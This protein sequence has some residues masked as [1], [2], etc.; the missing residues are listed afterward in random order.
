MTTINSWRY[1]HINPILITHSF[2]INFIVWHSNLKV[3]G[4][5]TNS[6]IWTIL[7]RLVT[8][9]FRQPEWWWSHKIYGRD[10]P[11]RDI[12]YLMWAT[13]SNLWTKMRSDTFQ[14]CVS[15]SF[16]PWNC[17]RRKNNAVRL[18][19]S[20]LYRR[21]ERTHDQVFQKPPNWKRWWSVIFAGDMDMDIRLEKFTVS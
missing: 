2:D 3:R 19:A 21:L 10:S 1:F 11:A 4:A 15:F 6:T 9:A 8:T 20:L 7:T 17:H 14:I 13:I 18:D 12:K 16:F 5:L